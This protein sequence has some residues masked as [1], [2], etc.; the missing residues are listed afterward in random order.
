MRILKVCFALL[1]ALS[2]TVKAQEIINLY[3]DSI[4][5]SKPSDVKERDASNG[6]IFGVTKPTLTLFLPRKEDATGAAVV[7]CPG[8]AYAV[9]TYQAEGI[10]TAEEFV[11][12]GVAAFVLKYRLPSDSTMIDKTIGPLQDAEQAIKDVRENAS[13][14]GIDTGRVGLMGFSAGGHLASTEA[15]HYQNPVIENN[16]GTNLRPDFLILVYPVISMQDSLTHL[17]TRTDLLGMNPSKKLIDEYS[18]ELHVDSNTPPTWITQAED[19]KL[20]TVDNS[21]IFY[22]ALR[23]HGVPAE[24][25]LY[26]HGGHGF[27][28]F[29]KTS[30][31]MQPL[32]EWMRKSGWIRD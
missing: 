1:I 29:E 14:W 19:D 11:K 25:H 12:H 10:R 21:I 4:P 22:E 15:T 9:L 32:F 3:P 16:D 23:H 27:V 18:N 17:Q 8:G 7:I 26:P 20:V 24:L 28:L 5:N 2:F 31:W 13:K 6:L 30:D